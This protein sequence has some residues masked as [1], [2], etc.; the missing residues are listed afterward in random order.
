MIFASRRPIARS[1]A[2]ALT[3]ICLI[4][5]RPASAAEPDAFVGTYTTSKDAAKPLKLEVTADVSGSY[6]GTIHLGDNALPLTAHLD[7]ADKA[8]LTG[9]FESSGKSFDFTATLAGNEIT[10]VSGKSTYVLTGEANPLDAPAKPV[11]PLDVPAKPVNPLDAGD[12]P[13]NSLPKNATIAQIQAAAEAGDSSAMNRLGVVYGNGQGVP[14]DYAKAIQWYTKAADAGNVDAKA[15]LGVIYD[16]GQ[17]VP[18]DAARALELYRAAAAAGSTFAQTRLGVMYVDGKG[19]KV[20]LVEAV[21][22]YRKAAEA[23]NPEGMNYLALCYLNGNGVD[24]DAGQCMAWLQKAADRNFPMAI[25]NVGQ[26][27]K[28]GRGVPKDFGKAMEWFVKGAHLGDPESM[29]LIAQLYET[30]SGMEKPDDAKALAWYR[31]A[32]EMGDGP[33]R[34]WLADNGPGTVP[35]AG[36]KPGSV[37]GK[38]AM[39]GDLAADKFVLTLEAGGNVSASDANGNSSGG[40]T[41]TYAD[42]TIKFDGSAGINNLSIGGAW[43]LTWKNADEFSTTDDRGKKLVLTRVAGGK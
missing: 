3:V 22:W 35:K 9:T 33:A 27:Y 37:V 2:F 40:P 4:A 5:S 21:K 39:G 16:L 31:S 12:K 15:N 30:G 7:P 20:D 8:R 38:W 13:V 36:G 41:Y 25:R 23:G 43:K 32:A 11:N 29:R 10:F 24:A 34:K 17:G 1:I 26:I 28:F 42:N 6:R 14:M 18:V 19:V